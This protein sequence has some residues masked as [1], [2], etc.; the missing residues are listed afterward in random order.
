[1]RANMSLWSPVSEVAVV[2]KA[3]VAALPPAYE[4]EVHSC[5]LQGCELNLI[6]KRFVRTSKPAQYLMQSRVFAFDSFPASEHE[7]HECAISC[8][9]DCSADRNSHSYSMQRLHDS[10]HSDQASCA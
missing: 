10:E 1:M 5:L 7:S 4:R 2:A 6:S 9:H 3:A 8:V